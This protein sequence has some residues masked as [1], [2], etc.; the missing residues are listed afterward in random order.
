M[1]ENRE[2][3]PPPPE[4]FDDNPDW[5]E[6][7]PDGLP[8]LD[9]IHKLKVARAKL[10]LSQ[11]DAAALLRVPVGS[12]RNWEQRRRDPDDAAKTLITLLYEHPQ[13]IQGWLSTAAE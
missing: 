5:T 10:G 6:V 7:Y 13:E 4:D 1:V 11:D 12:I 8:K 9:I 3:R 2:K